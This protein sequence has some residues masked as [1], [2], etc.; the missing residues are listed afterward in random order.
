MAFE[1]LA[2][3]RL[4]QIDVPLIDQFIKRRRAANLQVSTVN[5]ELATLR[6][7]FNLLADLRPDLAIQLPKVKLQGGENRRERVVS[8]EEE[9][10][11][12][13]AADPILKDVALI[14]FDCGFATGRKHTS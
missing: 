13:A 12:L 2:G 3:A 8:P 9:K 6:R 1:K 10:L 4:N 11:Y 7:M 5:R 14:L